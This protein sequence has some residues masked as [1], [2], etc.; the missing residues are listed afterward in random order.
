M[1]QE[2]ILE[3]NILLTILKVPIKDHKQEKIWQWSWPLKNTLAVWVVRG[4][5][6][7]K[8]PGYSASSQ[9]I[10]VSSQLF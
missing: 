10:S 5:E 8:Q 9:F 1:E 6:S 3:I 4:I 2:E 7:P